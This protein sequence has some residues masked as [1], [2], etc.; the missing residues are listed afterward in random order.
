MF[1]PAQTTFA[2]DDPSRMNGRLE[3]FDEI[4]HVRRDDRRVMIKR[5]LPDHM[6]RPTRKA[7]VRYRLRIHTDVSLQSHH[8]WRGIFIQQ[9]THHALS[10]RRSSNLF[11]GRPGLSRRR[12]KSRT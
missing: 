6:I 2:Q 11:R 10:P 9:Q 4:S 1:L 5:I 3:K 12:E 7:N 8:C